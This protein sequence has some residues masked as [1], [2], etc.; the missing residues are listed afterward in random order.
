[1]EPVEEEDQLFTSFTHKDAFFRLL[2][3]FLDHRPTRPAQ[4]EARLVQDLGSILDIYLPAP[5]LIDPHLGLILPPLIGAIQRLL[6]GT[7]QIPGHIGPSIETVSLQLEGP[8]SSSCNLEQDGLDWRPN[9]LASLGTVVWWVLKVRGWKACLSFFPPTLPSLPLLLKLYH[10]VPD[11]QLLPPSSWQLRYI[12]LIWLSLVSMI[13]F[14]LD[15]VGGEGTIGKL[16][17]IGTRAVWS[18]R[19]KEGDGAAGLLGRLFSRSDCYPLLDRFL[20]ECDTRI[21]PTPTRPSSDPFLKAT[22]LRCMANLAPSASVEQSALIRKWVHLNVSSEAD[23]EKSGL[24]RKLRVKVLGRLAQGDLGRAGLGKGK[25]LRKGR[26]ALGREGRDADTEA[27]EEHEE[28]DI[29]VPQEVEDVVEDLMV[30]LQDKDTIVRW[31]AAKYTSRLSILLPSSFADQIAE[32]VIG[33]YANDVIFTGPASST[34]VT[35]KDGEEKEQQTMDLSG[36]KEPTWHGA[37]LAIAEL[38]RRGVLSK[39]RLD[40]LLPWLLKALFFDPRTSSHS[41]G[42]SVRDAACYILWSL[43]RAFSKT[44]MEPYALKLARASITLAVS[45]REVTIRRA[46]SAAFQENVGRMGLFAHGIDVLAKT[47]F[48]SVGIRR[49]AFLTAAPLVA[50]HEIYRSYLLEHYSTIT[51][52]HWDKEMRVLGAAALKSIVEIDLDEMGP[53]LVDKLIAHLDTLDSTWIHGILLALGEL[54]L[55]FDRSSSPKKEEVLRKIFISLTRLRPT[56]FTSFSADQQLSASCLIVARSAMTSTLQDPEL[57]VTWRNL[58]ELCLTNGNEIVQDSL[59]CMWSRISELQS[60]EED[61]QRYALLF[62]RLMKTFNRELQQTLAR[63]LGKL[64]FQLTP[65]AWSVIE[66]LLGMVESG[67]KNF[68]SDVEARRNAFEAICQIVS[69]PSCRG[70]SPELVAVS[71]INR[72]FEALFKG[73]DDYT[74]DQRGD[75][76]SWIRMTCIRGTSSLVC[77]LLD[78]NPDSIGEWL[79]QTVYHRVVGTTL[80]LA[81]ERLD[82][83]RKVAGECLKD[84]VLRD[85]QKPEWVLPASSILRNLY[86]GPEPVRWQNS[87]AVI[88]RLVHLVSEQTYRRPLLEGLTLSIGSL[89][90]GNHKHTSQSFLAYLS[91]LPPS[92]PSPAVAS[93]L[94]ICRTLVDIAKSNVT[95]NRVYI[96]VLDTLVLLFE[97]GDLSRIAD[98]ASGKVT[99]RSIYSIACRDLGRIRNIQRVQASMKIITGMLTVPACASEALKTLPIL[100]NHRFPTVRAATAE[101]L[102]LILQSLSLPDSKLNTTFDELEDVL[103]STTWS[104]SPEESENGTKE[105]VRLYSSLIGSL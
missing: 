57:S 88:S 85:G 103:L 1:M 34:I 5:P 79:D 54:A 41:T 95:L 53:A 20:A 17:T 11:P 100:L 38:A 35:V 44:D 39:D 21:Q 47:D 8:S 73:L 28:Q 74:T 2:G 98:I 46:G 18:G 13:P 42:T 43:P 9:R 66:R 94:S 59:S 45:D 6:E 63:V 72:V 83:V 29:E 36:V 80:K 67:S 22:V 24:C 3:E 65:V 105:V 92:S 97:D 64:S 58:S 90:E 62:H 78:S 104:A 51:L 71:G 33:L 75:V 30:G 31:S 23:I 25:S 55:S 102:Y 49:M 7:E 93:L 40:E 68:V 84:I 52:R 60:I 37:S 61:I 26:L 87:Q 99:I 4:E 91:T 101:N 56:L 96:P 27:R 15:S 10:P 32:A 81:A 69:R 14:S 82:G 86:K 48:Y 19:G 70:S 77:S 89:S 16:F 50:Q 12:L 76:G